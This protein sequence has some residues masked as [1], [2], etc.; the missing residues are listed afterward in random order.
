MAGH[1][2]NGKIMASELTTHKGHAPLDSNCVNPGTRNLSDE[3]KETRR[4][5]E[6]AGIAPAE[7]ACYISQVTGHIWTTEQMRH[8]SESKKAQVSALTPDASSAD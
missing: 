1:H 8:L 5:M 6:G 7:Q 2:K 3:N 4:Q